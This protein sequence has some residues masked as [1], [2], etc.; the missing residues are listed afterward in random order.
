MMMGAN[1]YLSQ[2]AVS[3]LDPA[4]GELEIG[5]VI[6]MKLFKF[7]VILAVRLQMV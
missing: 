4:D 3:L 6:S 7:I 2:E 1:Q 5:V